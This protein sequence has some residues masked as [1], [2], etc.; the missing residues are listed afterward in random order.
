MKETFLQVNCQSL[1][2]ISLDNIDLNNDFDLNIP[3]VFK[4]NINDYNYLY[5]NISSYLNATEVEKSNS[6]F[7]DRDKV[8]FAVCR[9]LLKIILA[10]YTNLSIKDIIIAYGPWKKPYLM[11][12]SNIQFNISHSNYCCLIA[13]YKDDIGVDVEH[14]KPTENIDALLTNIIS[15][16]ENIP[17]FYSA[18]EKELFFYNTWTKKESVVKA[19]G[20]G[21][22]DDFSQI[23][24]VENLNHKNIQFDS[25]REIWQN[26]DF[27]LKPDYQGAL[28]FKKFMNQKIYP[29]FYTLTLNN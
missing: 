14:L 5:N 21:I 20:T 4:F 13:I 18:R 1:G 7:L 25:N 24:L 17:R 11:N 26:F 29:K 15:K 27:R 10:N 8:Q 22:D 3:T 9:A 23:R 2:L 19:L 12:N 28:T 16:K 6:Y